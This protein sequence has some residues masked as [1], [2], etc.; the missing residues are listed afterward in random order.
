MQRSIYYEVTPDG[1]ID[2]VFSVTPTRVRHY[3]VSLA[4]IARLD[5]LFYAGVYGSGST[6]AFKTVYRSK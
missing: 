3:K 2:T 6:K 4:S 5:R 1:K